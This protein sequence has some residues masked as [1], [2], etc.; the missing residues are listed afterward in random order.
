MRY[1]NSF[2]MEEDHIESSLSECNGRGWSASVVG[3][4]WVCDLPCCVPQPL[5]VVSVSIACFSIV[6]CITSVKVGPQDIEYKKEYKG[7]E[8]ELQYAVEEHLYPPAISLQVVQS[9][10]PRHL[11]SH[12][13]ILLDVRG[14]KEGAMNFPID[15]FEEKEGVS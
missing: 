13:R 14:A 9:E 4:N 1:T 11:Q 3:K 7:D 15:F 10:V 12:K 2:Q 5:C 8:L 6:S